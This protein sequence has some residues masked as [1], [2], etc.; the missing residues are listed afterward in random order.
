[1]EKLMKAMQLLIVLL[2]SFGVLVVALFLLFL[3]K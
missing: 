1:M 3:F 2:I